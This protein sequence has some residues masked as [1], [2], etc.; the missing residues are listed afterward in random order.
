MGLKGFIVVLQTDIRKQYLCFRDGAYE[1]QAQDRIGGFEDMQTVPHRWSL[2]I[3]CWQGWACKVEGSVQREQISQAW[4]GHCI[5]LHIQTWLQSQLGVT[6][7]KE[8]KAHNFH[9]TFGYVDVKEINIVWGDGSVGKAFV[10]QSWGSKF[11]S[12]GPI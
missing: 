10:L 2:L 12:L 1:G 5:V 7:D 11:K 4:K 3:K 6:E 8:I 9:S